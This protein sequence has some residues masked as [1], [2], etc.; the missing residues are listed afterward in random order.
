MD[1]H[2][3]EALA[4]PQDEGMSL[5][6]LPA[7]IAEGVKSPAMAIWFDDALFNRARLMAKYLANAKGM[8]PPHLIGQ[9]EACFAVVERSLTWKLSPFAVAQSTYQ[10]PGGQVGFEGKLCQAI[11]ENSGKIVGPVRYEH[12]GTVKVLI[13]PNKIERSFRTTDPA[14]EVAI[15][16]G[17]E[18][19]ERKDWDAVQGKFS[20]QGSQKDSSKKYARRD[21]NEN[22]AQGLGV[23]VRAQVKGEEEP[24]EWSFDLIQAYPLNSTLWATDPKTQICYTAVRRF[25]NVAAPGLFMGVPFDWEHDDPAERARDITPPQHQPAARPRRS[26]F[27]ETDGPLLDAEGDPVEPGLSLRQHYVEKAARQKEAERQEQEFQNA[28]RAAMGGPSVE[29]ESDGEEA[30]PTEPQQAQS[31]ADAQDDVDFVEATTQAIQA[32]ETMEDLKQVMTKAAQGMTT[33][34]NAGRDVVYKAHAARQKELGK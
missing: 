6:A 17:A 33:L 16:D 14:L 19:I 30:P 8:T 23:T 2:H 22:D 29:E 18:V 28:E 24:R 15:E 32:A 34:N 5:P 11:L 13:G 12:Y 26:D 31:E 27:S 3:N 4:D 20:I 21:W 10:T 1:G 25:A 9:P 7:A